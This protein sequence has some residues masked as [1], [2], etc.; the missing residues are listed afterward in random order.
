MKNRSLPQ[1]LLG[2]RQ[3]DAQA[4]RT[5]YEQFYAYVMTVALHYVGNRTEAKQVT[6]EAFFK[7]FAALTQ[8]IKVNNF[9]AWLRQITVRTAIDWLRK[10]QNFQLELSEEAWENSRTAEPDIFSKLELD[11]TLATI[12]QL[13]PVYRVTLLLY[14]VEGLSHP[15]IA[16]QLNVSA[17]TS[18]ANL[19]KARKQLRILLDKSLIF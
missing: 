4:Q 10:Q 18:R 9:K 19:A 2:C 5:L 3:R 1:L 11:E 12:Q 16:A 6:N 13:S 8:Q 14:A 17:S 7:A 15:E